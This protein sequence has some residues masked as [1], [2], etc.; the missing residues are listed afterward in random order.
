MNYK[1]ILVSIVMFVMILSPIGT[2]VEKPVAYF[3]ATPTMGNAPL[4]V[5]FTDQS[6]GQIGM[7]QWNFGDNSRSKSKYTI[8]T[9]T[10]VG[11][12]KV[13]LTVT[14]NAGSSTYSQI[15]TIPA[16]DPATS[17]P[18]GMIEAINPT[19]V[20]PYRVYFTDKSTGNPTAWLWILGDGYV[21]TIKNPAHTYT[22]PG[23]YVVSL[24]E[25]NSKGHSFVKLVNDVVIKAK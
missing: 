13:T 4:V 16:F 20:A 3:T 8:H 2:A 12:F 1:H 7:Y 24:R 18:K 22:K 15:I 10:N 6:T 23:K 14:N 17:K 9:Y 11:T 25:W 5:V 19:G 21:S